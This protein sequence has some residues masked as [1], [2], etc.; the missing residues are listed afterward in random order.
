MG[1]RPSLSAMTRNARVFLLGEA[2]L[3]AFGGFILPIYVL[4]FRYYG[5]SLFDVALLAAVFEASVLV[6]ELPTGLF[7]D[8]FGRKL[9]VVVGFGLFALSG[10]VFIALKSLI[11]FILAEILFGLAEAFISGAGEALAVDS[12]PGEDKARCLEKLFIRRSRIRIA[13][14]ALAMTVAGSAYALNADVTFVPVVFGGIA[15]LA[16]SL[17]YDSA[18]ESDRTPTR[19]WEPVV[20]L[21]S[22]L[23]AVSILKTIFIVSLIA[24]FAYE[25][26][27][28]F[29]QVLG[30]E[31]FGINP[32]YFG[33][34]TA[35]GVVGSFF[36]V[37]PV[38][39]R[40]SG[41]MSLPLLI[42]LAAGVAVTSF[43]N[44]PRTVWPFL[45]IIYFVA[46]ELVR[47]LFSTAINM[48][49]DSRGRATFLSGYNLTCSIGEVAS[50]IVVGLIASRIGLPFVFVIGGAV[51]VVSMIVALFAGGIS[52]AGRRE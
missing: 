21:F 47:P 6:F 33:F 52:P 5:I 2:V 25:G 40:F 27:D 15:G 32:G 10:L 37:G 9:S 13:V 44:G 34:F 23:R 35:A 46:R 26:A 17:F 12:F 18:G 31:Y 24:N 51:L 3:A 28:Q 7:A 30:S 22:R 49:I 1:D 50:G 8:R 41:N 16:L 42:L 4:Y 48:A 45:L 19:F 29:W 11:G 14:T 38:T 36:L 43:P 20:F 39:R